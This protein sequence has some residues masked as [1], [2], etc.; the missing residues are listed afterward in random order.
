MSAARY[1]IYIAPSPDTALWRFGSEV[2]GYDAANGLALPGFALP[3]IDSAA[4]AAQTARPRSYG[5]H[6]T[7]KAPFRLA[8]GATPVQLV[9]ALDDFAARRL[10]FDL[11]PLTVTSL[12]HG[13]G[14]F[15][16][17]TPLRP[18]AELV[19]LEE[20]VVQGFDHFRAPITAAERAAR[21]PEQLTERE[22]AHLDRFG[23]P[24]VLEDFQF[25]MTLSGFVPSPDDLADLLAEAM[26]NRIGT[27][28][29]FVDALTVFEQPAPGAA[30]RIMH[31]APLGQTL[32]D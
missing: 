31:R 7:L 8:N 19:A 11:G 17:L 20:E 10:A 23:Y 12:K 14:G 5:F 9:D 16:A 32:G 30:F 24:H 3:G 21:R 2:L 4:W 18:S 6:A 22:V 28:H 13:D 29:L 26:A 1:A 15:V 27:A 25:H